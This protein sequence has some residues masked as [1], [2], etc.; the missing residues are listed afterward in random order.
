MR[1]AHVWGAWRVRAGRQA[2]R[3]GLRRLRGYL[4]HC[5]HR[6]LMCGKII[7]ARTDHNVA[8]AQQ[9]G[10]E[11]IH[12]GERRQETDESGLEREHLVM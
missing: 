1:G 2:E 7:T 10:V 8:C 11:T 12:D 5:L 3:E 6:G 4:L 9:V